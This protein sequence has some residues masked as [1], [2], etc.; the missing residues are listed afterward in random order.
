MG[1]KSHYL[2]II[3]LLGTAC[4][5]GSES[6]IATEK[7]KEMKG[8]KIPKTEQRHVS[9]REVGSPIITLKKD[10]KNHPDL[11]IGFS[12]WSI[13]SSFS[14]F[15]LT[16]WLFGF[17]LQNWESTGLYL[18]KRIGVIGVSLLLGVGI[19]TAISILL[20]NW[21]SLWVDKGQKENAFVIPPLKVRLWRSLRFML[22]LHIMVNIFGIFHEILYYYEKASFRIFVG[23]L[24][25]PCIIAIFT[26]LG[27]ISYDHW[28]KGQKEDSETINKKNPVLDPQDKSLDV[29][30]PLVA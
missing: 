22:S 16:A 11:W 3:S 15:V 21:V 8:N 25:L 28:R 24:L 20:A 7:P 6:N 9:K 30:K 23:L 12:L 1:R 17:K 5:A 27:I 18:L 10:I 13:F 26:Y 4:M 19:Y 14:L 29:M 2:F